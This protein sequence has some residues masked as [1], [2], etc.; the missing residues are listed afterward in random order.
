MVVPAPSCPIILIHEPVVLIERCVIE[1]PPRS[2]IACE[3]CV[4]RWDCCDDWLIC[5]R[6]DRL[7]FQSCQI[8]SGL[9]VD[10]VELSSTESCPSSETG[11]GAVSRQRKSY[12]ASPLGAIDFHHDHAPPSVD[13]IRLFAYQRVTNLGTLFD[14]IA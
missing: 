14:L 10:I 5:E 11:P 4:D 8:T 9:W 3:P 12:A 6:I 7:E 13:D 2:T 1:P